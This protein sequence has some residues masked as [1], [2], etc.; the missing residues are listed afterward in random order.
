MSAVVIDVNV[1]VVA[2]AR[3]TEQATP[4]C[5]I[6]CVSALEEAREKIVVLDNSGLIFRQYQRYNS[7]KGQPGLGD[8]FFRWLYLNQ[9]DVA[10]CEIVS[11]TVEGNS[12]A[13]VPIA[14]RGFDPSDHVYIGVANAS[15]NKPTI[16]NATD[17]DWHEWRVQLKQHGFQIEFL[18]PDL[19]TKPRAL[20]P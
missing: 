17:T 11:L 6:N 2:N 20:I 15:T 1:L 7:F 19:M 10:H 13:E 18:C 3:E 5:V 14:L 12:F 4:D 9:G 8:F 16:L